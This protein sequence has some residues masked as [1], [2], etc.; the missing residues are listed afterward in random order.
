MKIKTVKR[1]GSME[2]CH[3]QEVEAPVKSA[4]LYPEEAGQPY[5]WVEIKTKSMQ[6]ILSE[7]DCWF[8]CY[9][10]LV[11]E[12]GHVAPSHFPD[13]GRTFHVKNGCGFSLPETAWIRYY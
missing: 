12:H 2:Q 5:K 11:S 8:D 7:Y 3:I 9:G 13:L 1:G 6:T 4:E 10:N